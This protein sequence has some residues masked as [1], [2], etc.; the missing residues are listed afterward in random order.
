[1][2]KY[3]ACTEKSTERRYLIEAAF[4]SEGGG[5]FRHL[6]LYVSDTGQ[7]GHDPLAL[8]GDQPTFSLSKLALYL[9]NPAVIGEFMPDCPWQDVSRVRSSVVWPSVAQSCTEDIV[10]QFQQ[11]IRACVGDASTIAV[12]LSGGL[13]STAVLYHA[14]KVCQDR[15]LIAI[16]S[17]LQDDRGVSCASVA[18]HLVE[19]LSVPCELRILASTPE[20][21]RQFPEAEWNAH[22]PRN[23]AMPRLNRAMA[24]IAETCGAEVLLTGS[25]ADELLGAVRYLLPF[26]LCSKHWCDATSYL[27]DIFQGGGIRRVETEVLALVASK[28]P[29]HFASQL[30][31][32]TNWPELCLFQAPS[33]LSEQ[34]HTTVEQWS[35]TWVRDILALHTQKHRSWAIADAWDALFP[36]DL[37]PQAGLIA[38][39]D[40][41]LH[42]AFLRYAMALP[43]EER[44]AAGFQEAYHRRKALVLRLYPQE[45]HTVLPH[46][47]QLFSQ[48]FDT[49]QKQMPNAERCVKYGLIREDRLNACNDTAV[50]GMVSALEQW[51]AGAEKVGAIAD[52]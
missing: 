43:L 1:M 13:D 30:Y 10:T 27:H 51:I 23:D 19:S 48:S 22:G 9:S 38:E 47:K 14:S 8:A 18:Q 40:P 21:Y 25:G 52:N 11:S 34:F 2:E 4:C 15:R 36:L 39:R 45:T 28:L 7:R 33:L 5:P 46:N 20:A 29:V 32:A 37:L 41:F 17:D 6:P 24:D 35:R 44:Y 12:A 16:T 50:L 49:Y 31:W 3:H 42:P 26:L